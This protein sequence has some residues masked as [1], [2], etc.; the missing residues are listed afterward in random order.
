MDI[1]RQKSLAARFLRV[2]IAV[3]VLA[4]V[5][6]AG[7]WIA[8][9]RPAVPLVPRS[10]VWT[11]KVQRG[12]MVRVVRGAGVLAPQDVRWVT[13]PV[14]GRVERMLIQPGTAIAADTVLLVL[15]NPDLEKEV[16]DAQWQL[17]SAQA[18]LTTREVSLRND[19]LDLRAQLAKLQAD[20]EQAKL[21]ADV[22]EKLFQ[23]G[24]LS[25][26]NYKLSKAKVAQL[27][28]LLSIERD[29]HEMHKQSEPAELAVE[30]A[31]LEQARAMYA[32]KQRQ[33]ASLRVCAGC[34]GVLQQ[35]ELEVEVG[36]QVTAGMALAKTCDP[37]QLKAVLKVPEVQARDVQVGQS[38]EVDT[39]GEI[40]AGTVARIDPGAQEGTVTVDVTLTGELPREA[41]PDLNVIG[42]VQ[43]E[44]LDDVLS[45]S[46]PV[47]S[48]AQGSGRLF[49]VSG[50][51]ASAVPVKYGSCSATAIQ[52]LEGLS[53]GD[54]VILSDMSTWDEAGEVRLE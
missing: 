51:R 46:R 44:R 41:R 10:S 21:Q 34:E 30:K 7:V 39:G 27:E 54:E 45:V 17:Q 24:L 6:A 2:G 37:R 9:L 40:I 12:P 5:A 16:L 14:E 50:E 42:T 31:K 35:W 43:I 25:E 32:L 26:R 47:G 20:H 18:E 3:R 4:L 53:A 11:G 48:Q 22:D 13:A 52:V 8:R 15:S 33:L 1:P 29:R 49:R 19:L 36:R 38:V 23:D 28:E